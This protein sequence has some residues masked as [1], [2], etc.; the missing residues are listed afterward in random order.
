MP[1]PEVCD[2]QDNDCD[3]LIDD[4]DP[5]LVDGLPFYTDGDGDGYGSTAVTACT[6]AGLA[7][8]D[9]D[10]DDT[11]ANIHPDAPESCDGVDRDCDGSAEDIPGISE[12]CATASCLEVLSAST[13]AA[14]GPYWLLLASGGAA[15][16]YCDMTTD[17]GGWTLGFVRNTAGLTSQGDFGAG[18][19]S[20]SALSTSPESA[21]TA[22]TPAMGWIDLNA[23]SWTTLHLSAYSAG[24]QTYRSEAIPASDLRLS[25]GE[26]GYRL[27]GEG[28]YYW[29]GGDTSY[30]DSGTGAIDNPAD[31][32]ADCRGHSSL[33][34][35][36]DFSTS[37]SANAGLTL[38]GADGSS[39][40]SATWGDGWTYYG[41]PGGAQAI[42]VR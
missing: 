36:W 41:T 8:L 3:G 32:T 40:L 1:E 13:S 15:E 37:L 18:D 16:V 39:F 22:T 6:A 25:F 19:V 27:Y 21:S 14:S 35:G 12:D 26:D 20:V 33:G 4:A 38:C 7:L 17:G 29:C 10:C 34:G 2:E 5:D 24:V 9:G 23:M 28:G 31:A 42:W 30:T 11:D